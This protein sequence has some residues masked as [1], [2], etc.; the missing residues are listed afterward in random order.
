MYFLPIRA[1]SIYFTN[2]L[3]QNLQKSIVNENNNRLYVCNV[4]VMNEILWNIIT[5][6]NSSFLFEYNLKCH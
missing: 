2:M 3:T 4:T 5:F 1:L 6:E